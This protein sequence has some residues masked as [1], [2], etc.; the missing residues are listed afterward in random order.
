M[1]GSR[2]RALVD[3]AS[4]DLSATSDEWRRGS[5]SVVARLRPQTYTNIAPLILRQILD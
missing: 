5:A 4:A 3:P 2:Q 1:A